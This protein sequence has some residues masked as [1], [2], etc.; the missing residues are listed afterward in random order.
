MTKDGIY[1]SL[2]SK[3]VCL[4]AFKPLAFGVKPIEINSLIFSG[5]SK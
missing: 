3:R 4:K 2:T 1:G 5:D